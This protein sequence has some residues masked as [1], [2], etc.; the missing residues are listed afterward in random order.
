MLYF[1]RIFLISGCLTW[2]ILPVPAKL[3][4]RTENA[5]LSKNTLKITIFSIK[6][7]VPRY[8][9]NVKDCLNLETRNISGFVNGIC[10]ICSHPLSGFVT[11]GET[12]HRHQPSHNNTFFD[13]ASYYLD[14]DQT[15]LIHY[16]LLEV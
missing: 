11:T 16:H 10:C 14:I 15:R 13:R 9:I 3:Y 4:Q 6:K 2:R 12:H 8:D 7:H 1:D 5:N